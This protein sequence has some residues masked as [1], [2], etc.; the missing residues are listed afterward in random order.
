MKSDILYEIHKKPTNSPFCEF[1]YNSSDKRYDH[2][3]FT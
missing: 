2:E 3:I 1:Q